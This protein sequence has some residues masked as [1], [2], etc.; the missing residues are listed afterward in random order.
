MTK[1]PFEKNGRCDTLACF[2]PHRECGAKDK[3]GNPKYASH[4]KVRKVEA[5]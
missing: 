1:C 5:Q 2:Y 4:P 3:K